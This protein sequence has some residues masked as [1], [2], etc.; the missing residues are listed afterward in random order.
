MKKIKVPKDFIC[1]LTG[2]IM[3]EPVKAADGNI[4][5]YKAIKW[6]FKRY[7]V[8]P[9][10]LGGKPI[11]KML[12]PAKETKQKISLFLQENKVCSPEDFLIIVS[13]GGHK[14]NLNNIVYLD[15]YLTIE[16]EECQTP[17][18]TAACK[19][20]EVIVRMLL[21]DIAEDVQIY[22]TN[23]DKYGMSPLHHASYHG[24]YT[25]VRILISK[26]A[27]V[28]V[29]DNNG[30]TP[31]HLAAAMGHEN[32]VNV[33]LRAKPD[34]SIK[35]NSKET[36]LMEAM[37]AHQEKVA[38]LLMNENQDLQ[39]KNIKGKSLLH[40]AVAANMNDIVMTLIDKIDPNIQDNKGNTPLHVAVK[41]NFLDLIDILLKKGSNPNLVNLSGKKAIELAFTENAFKMIQHYTQG[42]KEEENNSEEDEIDLLKKIV[43]EQTQIINK[44]KAETKQSKAKTSLEKTENNRLLNFF[45]LFYK[46][47]L[48]Y[49]FFE[50]ELVDIN[51]NK[52]E[53]KIQPTQHQGSIG[54][55]EI[56]DWTLEDVKDDGNCFYL[57]VVNQLKAMN[58]SFLKSIPL[59]TESNDSL[60][61]LI[62]GE[63]F[64]DKEWA[65]HQEILTLVQKLK[66]VVAIMDT[67]YPQLGFVY[68]YSK[69]S[70]VLD[71]T[72][73]ETLLPK[74]T[75][76][77]K[78]AFTGD[79]YLS[80]LKH[81]ELTNSKLITRNKVNH[82]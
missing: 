41:N 60:R 58:H 32:V 21:Q 26:G 44:L 1:P 42:S 82:Q 71:H 66:V 11:T 28:N 48:P 78:L 24:H 79:H 39:E 49:E 7:D 69:T 62:Q 37:G 14:L 53:S 55:R 52:N 43:A 27:D 65:D 59:N 16:G 40:Y 63:K 45:E 72:N 4:Y 29:Q 61:L 19:G 5:E 36:A 13:S 76:V 17:L 70:N 22:L 10:D 57:A 74:D 34:F 20:H 35:N 47:T 9:T 51:I 6:W 23:L 73:D 3:Q 31:L 77:I 81:P 25:I 18:H 8:S 2:Q 38:K 30:D 56:K 54:P 33:L 80:V 15:T 50:K 75:P 64:K 67:R 68:H 46:R 12:I